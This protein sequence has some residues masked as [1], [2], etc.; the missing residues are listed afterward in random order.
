MPPSPLIVVVDDDSA[1]RASL[2]ALLGVE[3]M[4]VRSHPSAEA[5]LASGDVDHCDCLLV[6]VRMDGLT[7]LEL[8]RRL[9]EDGRTIPTIVITGHADVPMAV[10]ALKG[11][12]D[13][14]IEKPF[15]GE[16]IASAVRAVLAQNG[17]RTF[18]P[19]DWQARQRL[20]GLTR[21]ETEVLEHLVAGKSNKA[22][23]RA[24]GISHRTVEIHRANLMR[25][26]KAENLP[27]LVRLAVG[28][29]TLRRQV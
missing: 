8:H 16:K 21:R 26:M 29:Q 5:F 24:L 15:S 12:A 7:G 25:K 28:A 1:V 6:D 2:T 22:I 14:F 9:R 3:G 10:E 17:H 19:P 13:D 4:R 23:A 27:Q 11:G 18:P 20:S